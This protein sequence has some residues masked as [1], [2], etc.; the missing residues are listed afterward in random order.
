MLPAAKPKSTSLC[1]S[2][3]RLQQQGTIYGCVCQFHFDQRRNMG[4]RNPGGHVKIIVLI[5]RGKKQ[6]NF[7]LK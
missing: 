2:L 3:Q 6:R 4:I 7:F 1:H 5:G